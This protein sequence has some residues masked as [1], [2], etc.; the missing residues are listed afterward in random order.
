MQINYHKSYSNYLNRDME[1]K[2]C[3]HAG[4]VL[5]AFPSQDGRFYDY[6]NRNLI[7]SIS[8]QIDQGK[9]MVLCCDSI[10]GESWSA[11]WKNINDRI[12]AHEAYFNYIYQELLPLFRDL[13]PSQRESK[14]YTTGC[15]LGAYHALNILFR[16]PDYLFIWCI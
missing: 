8:N 10:D 13:Y 7:Q 2:V 5:L 14:V 9:V 6:E 16:M 15:S 12:R 11:E 4:I 3:G 1:F